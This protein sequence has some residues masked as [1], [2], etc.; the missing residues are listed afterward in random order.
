V[1]VVEGDAATPAPT[2]TPSPNETVGA[3]TA[4]PGQSATP[5]PTSSSG[6]IPGANGSTPLAPLIVLL[7]GLLAASIVVRRR[8]LSEGLD[9]APA[10]HRSSRTR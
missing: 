5:P 9:R 10:A 3:E 1:G 4:M 6:G 8:S 2:P 7:A